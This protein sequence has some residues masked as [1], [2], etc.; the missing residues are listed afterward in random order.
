MEVK[1]VKVVHNIS[2]TEAVNTVQ[3]AKDE[4]GKVHPMSTSDLVESHTPGAD[5]G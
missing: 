2:Y 3:K 1:Q 5:S 4:T